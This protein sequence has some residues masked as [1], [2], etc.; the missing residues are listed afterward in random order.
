VHLAGQAAARD[1]LGDAAGFDQLLEVDAGL[2]AQAVQHVD[3]IL[4]REVARGTRR[5]RAAAEAS[6]GGVEVADPL[7]QA[8]ERVGEGRAPRVVQVQGELVRRTSLKNMRMRFRVWSGV[9]T[10]IVSPSET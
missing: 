1:R 2:D 7:V 9:P 4:G 3:E 6:D 5:V 8:D 10:P